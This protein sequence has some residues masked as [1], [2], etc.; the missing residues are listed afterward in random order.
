MKV[1]INP[2]VYAGIDY[3]KVPILNILD[4]ICRT[5]RV[6]DTDVISESR[7]IEFVIARQIFCFVARELTGSKYSEIGKVI[8]RDRT[9]VKYSCKKV[10]Q[11]LK[12]NDKKTVSMYEKV[13][14]ILCNDFNINKND[15][16]N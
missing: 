6:N 4:N 15:K 10:R 12:I 3:S 16:Q 2:Y 11:N 9:S 14:H 8:N 5:I 1:K 13:K 7:K